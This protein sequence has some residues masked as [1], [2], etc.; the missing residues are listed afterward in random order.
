MGPINMTKKELKEYLKNNLKLVIVEYDNSFGYQDAFVQV[1]LEL[2][3]EII[4]EESF[5]VS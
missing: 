5:D 4:S 2:E 1:R 3:N